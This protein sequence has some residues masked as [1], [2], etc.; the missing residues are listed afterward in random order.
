MDFLQLLSDMPDCFGWIYDLHGQAW[1]WV[2]DFWGY[3]LIGY[4][5]KQDH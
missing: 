5:R 1:L 3:L 2:G 4:A